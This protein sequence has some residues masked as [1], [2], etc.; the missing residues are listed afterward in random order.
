MNSAL[1]SR[2]H[3][4]FALNLP[5]RS[6][7]EGGRGRPSCRAGAEP[8]TRF[9]THRFCGGACF[10]D[11]SEPFVQSPVPMRQLVGGSAS[12]ES[13]S[14]GSLRRARILWISRPHLGRLMDVAGADRSGRT[15]EPR[16]DDNHG[17]KTEISPD[18][19]MLS[20]S[21]QAEDLHP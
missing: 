12:L 7:G 21:G 13:S 10:F 14:V 1:P 18:F 11:S 2:L 20:R 3:L 9:R 15:R 6:E 5:G 17:T 16:P 8:V 19:R 4:R